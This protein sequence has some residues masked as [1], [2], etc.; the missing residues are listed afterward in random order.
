MNDRGRLCFY[1]PYLYPVAS[2]GE[3]EFVGGTEVRQW[4]LARALA[5]RGFDVAIATCDFG[6]DAIVV[7]DGVTLLRTYSTEAGIP[8]LRL[9]Y[10]RLWKALGTLRLAN[11]DVYLANG[12]GIA[13]GWAYDAARLRRS[14]FV[15]L[16]A[17]DGDAL[18]SLPWLTKRRERW[19][20]LRALRGADARVAQTEL[21][22]GLFRDNFAVETQVIVNP[23][24]FP[25]TPVD[26]GANNVVLWLSTYKPSKRPEWFIEL[27]RRLPQLRFV[28]V[29]LPRSGEGTE[30]WQAAQRAA[31]QSS[32]LEVHGFVEHARVGE[33]LSKAAL[34]VHTSPAE[35]FPMTLLE[36]WSYGIP[37]VTTVDP[38]GTVER[39]RLGEVVTSRDRLAESV[40]RLMGSPDRRRTLGASAREYVERH[41]G[42]DQTYEPLAT[43]LD[44]V[45]EKGR[46]NRSTRRRQRS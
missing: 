8:A 16:A 1:S 34:F 13:T 9:L 14:R 42:P 3:I 41:H 28:M 18:R 36:A 19:W 17:S 38:G 46:T 11:A 33:F 5:A 39:Q 43:L 44:R 30:S 4:A 45:I 40:A 24:E 6:Q 25:A 29:G 15:F 12:S 27:A 26:A 37:S 32:N 20:Y 22:R 31:A 10:P 7:R 21:Q 2:G 23:V 35:G